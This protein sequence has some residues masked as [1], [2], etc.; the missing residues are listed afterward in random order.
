MGKLLVEDQVSQLFRKRV[1]S[2]PISPLG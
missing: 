2:Q 1:D